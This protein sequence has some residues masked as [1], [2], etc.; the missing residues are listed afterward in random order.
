MWNE[1]FNQFILKIGFKGCLSDHC[2]YVRD[3]NGIACCVLLYVDDLLIVSSDMRTINAIKQLFSNEFEITDVGEASAFL[4]VHIERD[5][6]NHSI[7]MSQMSYL[8]KV[9]RKFNMND[10]K[11]VST[12]IENGIDLGKCNSN[13][14]CNAPYRELMGCLTYATIT[15]RPD[16]CAAT[17]HFSRFQS[18]Y[19]DEHFKCAKRT[20]RYIKGTMDLKLVYVRNI[21]AEPLIGYTDADW[22]GDKNDRKSTSGYVYKVFGNTVGW[23]SRKQPTVSLSSTEAEYIALSNGICGG[24]WLRGLL[25]ELGIT[26]DRAT[27][28]HEDN[29]SCIRIADEPRENKRMKHIDVKY[30]FIRESIARGDFK[31]RYIP[32][33]DQVA[34]I[35][36]KVLGRQL[37][38]KHRL[39]LNLIS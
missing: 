13:G 37:F 25:S 15:T 18:C 29:Q 10:C 20:L 11:E 7:S 30:N 16:L 31:L 19:D 6:N 9:L 32:T 5:G 1:R 22:A 4:G 14:D 34:D 35:M 17:N 26:F 8:A 38:E 33:G 2:L 21:D 12:P 28:I 3:V 39:S 36:T 24:K 23:S 27:T